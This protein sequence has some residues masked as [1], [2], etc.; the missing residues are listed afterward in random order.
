MVRMANMPWKQRWAYFWHYYKFYMF[1]IVVVLVMLGYG[2]YMSFLRPKTDI[3]LLWLSDRYDLSCE[4]ALR[5]TL[6]T[7]LDWDLNEDGTV[8]VRLNHVDFSVPYVELDISAQAELLTLYSAEDSCIYLLS[9]CAVE[10]M[11]ENDL[12]GQ[13]EDAGLDGD[14]ILALCAA[15]LPIFGGELFT[16]LADAT[17]CIAKPEQASAEA[18]AA[19]MAA[20]RELLWW[21]PNFV[22]S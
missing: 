1:L 19:Q 10:W 2:L 8:C 11:T 22:N 9:S 20:L 3:S 6:E 17:L 15:D 18:Y 14:G 5:E 12:L 7:Q 4:T 13:W 16:P 21:E